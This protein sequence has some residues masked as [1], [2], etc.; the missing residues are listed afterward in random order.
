MLILYFELKIIKTNAIR[1]SGNDNLVTVLSH[2]LILKFVGYNF[3]VAVS[4]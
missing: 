4:V 3:H 2:L 1:I